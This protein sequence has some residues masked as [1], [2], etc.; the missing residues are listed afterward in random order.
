MSGLFRIGL[1]SFEIVDG[2]GDGVTGFFIRTH[3][4]HSVANHQQ[5]LKRYHDFV[6]FN[7]VPNQHQNFFSGHALLLKKKALRVIDTG[8]LY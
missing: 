7:K 8:E 5:H 1:M 4:M 2:G 3:G 6:I